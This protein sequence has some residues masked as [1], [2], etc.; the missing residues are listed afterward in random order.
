MMVVFQFN[1][2]YRTR[3]RKSIQGRGEKFNEGIIFREK[4]IENG[5]VG[6]FFWEKLIAT[7]KVGQNCQRAP[8]ESG[9]E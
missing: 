9:Y 7:I 4:F 8:F 6:I 2:Y 5:L 3:G 1:L